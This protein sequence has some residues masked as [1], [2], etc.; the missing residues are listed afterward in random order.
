MRRKH[1]CITLHTMLC[2]NGLDTNINISPIHATCT[3]HLF[4]I[5]LTPFYLLGST[6]HDPPM[7]RTSCTEPVLG[8]AL[9]IMKLPTRG[10]S[11][12]WARLRVADSRGPVFVTVCL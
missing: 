7:G 9:Q 11:G 3:I 4:F 2:T 8:F 6:D 10:L 5:L 12:H 1:G